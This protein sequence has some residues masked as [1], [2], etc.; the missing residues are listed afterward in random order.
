M[1]DP[2]VT[3]IITYQTYSKIKEIS[4]YYNSLPQME[5]YKLSF[6]Y[7]LGKLHEISA[8]AGLGLSKNI[9]VN[10]EWASL[11]MQDNKEIHNAFL[12]TLG[13]ELAH[14]DGDFKAKGNKID[15]KFI[16]WIT[17]VHQILLLLKKW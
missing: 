4:D 8:S 15:R 1:I 3:L 2:I 10:N 14:K 9:W 7:R 12:L 11:L 6:C 16:H 17:E 5:K 13:H